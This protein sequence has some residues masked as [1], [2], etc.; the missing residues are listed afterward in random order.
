M[1]CY[2]L[3][4]ADFEKCTLKISIRGAAK[5]LGVS[6]NG[7]RRG[8][9]QLLDEG[10]LILLAKG[11]GSH[12]SQYEFACPPGHEACALRSRSVTPPV[13]RR[14]RSA[15]VACTERTRYVT[16]IQISLLVFRV[17]PIER[18]NRPIRPW[19]PVRNRPHGQRKAVQHEASTTRAP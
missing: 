3:Y 1:A 15:H 18:F 2:A 11:I 10:V 13:T 7:V 19:R 17:I 14:D 9:Q 5:V 16:P 8:L 12:R 4:W 6:P